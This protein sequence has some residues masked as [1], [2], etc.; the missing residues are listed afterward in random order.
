[1]HMLIQVLP[2]YIHV[3]DWQNRYFEMPIADW[4]WPLYTKMWT[5]F[6]TV[7]SCVKLIYIEWIVA[8]EWGRQQGLYNQNKI[9]TKEDVRLKK[10]WTTRS[11]M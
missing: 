4:N 2:A 3:H 1:M 10:K 9:I 6:I 8:F 5:F 11:Y 7:V